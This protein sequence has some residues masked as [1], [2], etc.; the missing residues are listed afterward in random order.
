MLDDHIYLRQSLGDKDY[1]MVIYDDK[2]KK[3]EV[4]LISEEKMPKLFEDMN[5]VI[6]N[7]EKNLNF[8]FGI[9]EGGEISSFG[10]CFSKCEASQRTGTRYTVREKFKKIQFGFS[11]D[12]RQL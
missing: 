11:K 1:F 4:I 2:K 8:T 6:S 10:K 12:E 9:S 5:T 7:S 3:N